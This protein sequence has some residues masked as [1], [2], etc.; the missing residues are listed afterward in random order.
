LALESN[1]PS[2]PNEGAQ[3]IRMDSDTNNPF[4]S[5]LA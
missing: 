5:N 4:K 1:P 3:L 2:G